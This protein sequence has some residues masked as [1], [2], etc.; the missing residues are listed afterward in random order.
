MPMTLPDPPLQQALR[1]VGVDESHQQRRRLRTL[2]HLLT[3]EP[4]AM[5]SSAD[6]L[7]RQLLVIADEKGV[8]EIRKALA[9][10]A[11]R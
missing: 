1:A 8:D 9:Q 2:V 10:D 11:F 6:D 7:A 3:G 4:P 5:A